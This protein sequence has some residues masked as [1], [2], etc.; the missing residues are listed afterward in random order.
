MRSCSSPHLGTERRLVAH[1]RGHPAEQSRDLGARLR[2]P[3]DIVD[4]KQRVGAGLVAEM[5]GHGERREGDSKPCT[6]RLVHLTKD[7]DGLVDDPLAGVADLGF[8]HLEPQVVALASALADAGKARIATVKPC[9]ARDQL[10]DDDGLADAGAAEQPGL[11]ATHQRAEQVH[12]LDPGLEHL[13]LG[14][15]VLELGRLA[16]NGPALGLDRAAIVDHVPHQV[17]HPAE[18]GFAHR[19]LDRAAG[20]GD[21]LTAA[22]AVGRIESHRTHAAAAQMLGHLAPQGLVLA[23]AHDHALDLDTERVVDR[24]QVLFGELGV[25]HRADDLS[26]FAVCCLCHFASP[27]NL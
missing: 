13:G 9:Q 25:Q 23:L 5:L 2:K 16:V 6:G 10:L 12:D 14:R 24:R 20:V 1:G 18:R 22:D 8:L 4:K 7:H 21:L 19:H 27:L 26:D 3:K 11:A 17:E 15:Q